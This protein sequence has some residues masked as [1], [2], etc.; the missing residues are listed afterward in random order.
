MFLIKRFI[1]ITLY[2]IIPQMKIKLGKAVHVLAVIILAFKIRKLYS[3]RMRKIYM[4]MYLGTWDFP[5][6]KLL[7]KEITIFCQN[8]YAVRSKKVKLVKIVII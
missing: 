8:K 5:T 3:F 4:Y 2:F 7:Y 6:P 1:N